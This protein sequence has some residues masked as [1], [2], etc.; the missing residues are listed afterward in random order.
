MEGWLCLALFKHF[1]QAPRE[2]YG[3]AEPKTR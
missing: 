1:E 2:L 3:R